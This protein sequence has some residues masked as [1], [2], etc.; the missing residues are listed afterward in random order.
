V[1]LLSY[2]QI[3]LNKRGVLATKKFG[4]MRPSKPAL[5]CKDRNK[6]NQVYKFLKTSISFRKHKYGAKTTIRKEKNINNKQKII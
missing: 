2:G 5:N 1:Q 3:S 4:K 6:T